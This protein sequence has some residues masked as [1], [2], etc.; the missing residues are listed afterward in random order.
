MRRRTD[1]RVG[2]KNSSVGPH[3]VGD[4]FGQRDESAG[5]S[6]R[7]R[8]IVVAITEKPE[9]KGVLFGE[10][11]VLLRAVV[12][13]AEHLDSEFLEFIPAV[14]QPVGF[15]RSTRG[16]G[17]WIEEQQERATLEISPRHRGAIMGLEFKIDEWL[18]D[19][20]HVSSSSVSDGDEHRQQR[21]RD[22]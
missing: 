11:T 19:G 15:Q 2:Y 16:A 9:R 1:I 5:R 6:D 17:L 18:F 21:Q 4:A 22:Q 10:L 8:Q 12:G 14:P 13:D 3:E 20:N 7:L